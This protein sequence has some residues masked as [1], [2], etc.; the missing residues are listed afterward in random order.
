MTTPDRMVNA[1]ME[2]RSTGAWDR[3]K[4]WHLAKGRGGDDWQEVYCGGGIAFPGPR[5]RV[6]ASRLCPE[7]VEAKRA[8]RRKT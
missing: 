5:E 7:C 1:V 8:K 4:V 6:A 2:W 3:R